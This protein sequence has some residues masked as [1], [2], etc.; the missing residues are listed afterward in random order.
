MNKTRVTKQKIILVL[1]C[2][3]FLILAF[4]LAC[5]RS[6]IVSR[7][8]SQQMAER[9]SKDGDI[10]QISCFFS[11]D[12][13]MSQDRIVEFEH[14]LDEVLMEASITTESENPDARLWTD[15][16]SASQMMTVST[17]RYGMNVKSIGVGGDFFRF[18]PQE[19]IYGNYFY[20]SDLNKDYVIIDREIASQLFGGTEVNGK[21]LEV[22]GVPHVIAGVIKRPQENMDKHAGLGEPILYLSYE[23]FQKLG[24]IEP[25]NHYEIVMPNPVKNYAMGIVKEKLGADE[26]ETDYVEN[27]D[28]YSYVNSLIELKDFAYR[29]MNGK[30]IIYPY[31]ENLSR[32][33]EDTLVFITLFV[34]IFLSV[35]SII[36]AIWLIILWK[37]K[38]WTWKSIYEKL[39]NGFKNIRRKSNKDINRDPIKITFVDEEEENE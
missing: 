21:I 31:W 7:Q 18:H 15:A 37:N 16:Y 12:C 20:G 29:S 2:L 27:T 5:I 14:T 24:G 22:N 36:V 19:L 1:T 34:V 26:N 6:F 8:L 30:A 3:I 28:R 17:E 38:K 4:I 13:N 23:S 35:P 10:A 39:G 25:I 33:I 11:R 32:G 9:W